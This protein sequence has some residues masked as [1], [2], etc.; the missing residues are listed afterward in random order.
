MR[1][2]DIR[3]RHRIPHDARN[4]RLFDVCC[5]GRAST[6]P[7]LGNSAGRPILAEVDAAGWYGGLSE[8]PQPYLNRRRLI[9][10][11]VG[12]HREPGLSTATVL[13][14]VISVAMRRMTVTGRAIGWFFVGGN[15][16]SMI[17]PCMTKHPAG[18]RCA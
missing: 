9:H 12:W 7:A 3:L 11:I 1:Q 17:L 18:Q 2:L 6:G 16:G 14:T 10:G 15:L 5:L 4:S 8:Q 13:P